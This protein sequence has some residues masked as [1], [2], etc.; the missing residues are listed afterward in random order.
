MTPKE[1][2]ISKIPI[3]D[4]L[5]ELYAD[6]KEADKEYGTT[7][8]WV[9][10]RCPFLDHVDE[11]PSCGVNLD[12]G[13]FN[14]L[15]CGKGGDIFQLVSLK[16][17]VSRPIAVTW[18]KQKF[19]LE[20]EKVISLSVAQRY[21][22]AIWNAKKHLELLQTIKG[23]NQKTIETAKLGYMDGK[24]TIPIFSDVGQ[25]LNIKHYNPWSKTEKYVQTRGHAKLRLYP[26]DQFV[27]NQRSIVLAEGELK[28]LLFIQ[29]GFAAVS[30]TGGC[31]SWK[32][33]WNTLF[34]DMIVYIVYDIDKTGI[35]TARRRAIELAGS[36]AI[37]HIV[38]LP[39]D[40]DR[41]PHGDI[42]NWVV[43]EGA[44]AEAIQTLFDNSEVYN[45]HRGRQ[46]QL[47]DLTITP[48]ELQDITKAKWAGRRVSSIGTI[49]SKDVDPFIIPSA[50]TVVCEKDQ[51]LCGLCP[52][53][54]IKE[55]E[56][57]PLNLEDVTTLRLIDRPDRYH[58]EILKEAINI[59]HSCKSH[60]IIPHNT[61]NVEEINFTPAEDKHDASLQTITRA[62]Y[63]GH[64]L[65]PNETY[66]FDARVWPHPDSQAACSIVFKAKETQSS[67][68][69]FSP[70]SE[71]H[72]RL[73]Q[74]FSTSE[75]GVEEKLSAIYEDLS[76][77][78]TKIYG[79]RLMHW[80]IDTV[81]HS[82]LKIEFLGQEVKGWMEG[83]LI[84]DPGQGKSEVAINLI[85]HYGLGTRTV[86]KNATIAGLIGACEQVSNRWTIT[87]GILPRNDKGLVVLEECKGCSKEVIARLT[88]LRS[89]GIAEL[90]KVRKQRTQARVR[91][92][93][94]SNPRNDL[95][96]KGYSFGVKAIPHL[97]GATED[98][99][100]FDLA[101]LVATGEIDRKIVNQRPDLNVVKHEYTSELCRTLLLWV[102]SR[103]VNQITFTRTAEDEV[104]KTAHIMG[105]QFSSSIP[106]VEPAD[107]R[108]KLA[109]IAASIAAR[110]YSTPD[111]IQLL[112]K[113]EHVFLAKKLLY[114]LY[115]SEIMAYDEYS[116]A[117]QRSIELIDPES[118]LVELLS[119]PHPKYLMNGLLRQV[120]IRV[121]DI[122]DM[123]GLTQREDA[124]ELCGV[125]IRHNAITRTQGGYIKRPKFIE[126]LRS[127][128]TSAPIDS[129]PNSKEKF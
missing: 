57:L 50:V 28:A 61:V 26:I 24:I 64:G 98:I 58:S 108:Y 41:Y 129:I 27:E 33:E 101:C 36:G 47:E 40:L 23:L 2:L 38:N 1:L 74:T 111:G 83:L 87:W 14:C 105:K 84:G 126:L 51:A 44:T 118:V 120:H 115:T 12:T 25:V 123:G 107:Q 117:E 42:T 53:M 32:P 46:T 8:R 72:S 59:P 63:L 19:D 78:V 7:N 128:A 116:K 106:L 21:H 10:V 66:D 37:P 85:K 112:V 127:K 49:A 4:V 68:T 79:R 70:S 91:L 9:T 104:L 77:N 92:L 39:L 45:L 52:V 17:S 109:R 86:T 56:P 22:N 6:V 62:F 16:M 81:W 11:N 60:T 122:M 71:I 55:G 69:T 94:I 76:N 125:L 67:L 90:V 75:N 103:T 124:S 73:K 110:T 65:V 99:R 34:Q 13:R 88:D 113:Q 119:V 29:L 35:R 100:R 82:V 95:S 114:E 5:R 54:S 93:W 121:T 15:G 89:S 96:V 97:V 3:E 20:E 43:D 80:F 18:I 31:N 102:W 30:T 48:V